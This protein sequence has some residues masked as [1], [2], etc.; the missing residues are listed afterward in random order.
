MMAKKQQSEDQ[1][2]RVEELETQLKQKE[3]DHKRALADYQN[4]VQRSVQEKKL[5]AARAN[6]NLLEELLPTLDHLELALQHFSDPSL[7]MIADNLSRTLQEHG[8]K[9]MKV[10]GQPFDE[11]TMEAVDTAAGPEGTVVAEQQAGYWLNGTVLRH[12]RVSVGIGN[13]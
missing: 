6:A 12:A 5:H 11:H 1:A 13:K 10:V 4:L 9:K 8:L 7:Q 3:E 2:S